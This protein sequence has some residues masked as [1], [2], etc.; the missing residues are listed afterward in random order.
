MTALVGFWPRFRKARIIYAMLVDTSI[1]R[2][3]CIRLACLGI[4]DGYLRA[5]VDQR[6]RET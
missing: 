4:H 3:C 1:L 6:L 5:A 2:G